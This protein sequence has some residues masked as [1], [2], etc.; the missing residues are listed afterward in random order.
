[1]GGAAAPDPTIAAHEAVRLPATP[2]GPLLPEAAD[3]IASLLRELTQ[4]DLARLLSIVEPAPP[5]G[6]AAQ[7]QELLSAAI[8]AAPHNSEGALHSVRQMAILDPQRAEGMTSEPGLASI[9]P[10]IE[11]LLAQL[12]AA[13]KLNA[14]ARL[15]EAA[16]KSRPGTLVLNPEIALAVAGRLIDAGGLAN[17]V[18]SEAVSTAIIDQARWAPVL[19]AEPVAAGDHTASGIALRWLAIVWLVVGLSGALLC[20]WLQYDRLTSVFEAWAAGLVVLACFAAWR[21][22][23]RG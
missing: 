11:K 23:R 22:M 19:Q 18:R 14:E 6:L 10:A 13:A 21:W 3:T 16:G 17:Y 9:R 5:Q 20:W 15:A 4:A 2:A 1:M 8:S 7:V 12:T